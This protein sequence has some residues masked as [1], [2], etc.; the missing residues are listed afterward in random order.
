MI[1]GFRENCIPKKTSHLKSMS[2][3]EQDE[4]LGDSAQPPIHHGNGAENSNLK[5]YE[6]TV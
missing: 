6:I 5:R 3:D 1:E 2:H 4:T